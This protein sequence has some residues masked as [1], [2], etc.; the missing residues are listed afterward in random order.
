[1]L[2]QKSSRI[3]FMGDSITDCGATYG[4][5]PERMGNGY[6]RYIK[7]Y[8]NSRYPELHIDVINKGISGHRTC[9]LLKRWEDDAIKLKPDIL[10]I[11]IGTNDVWRQFDRP[12]MDVIDADMFEDNLSKMI[13]STRDA[14]DPIIVLFE[15][16]PVEK[17]FRTY[18][19]SKDLEA[20][21]NA[22]IDEY[23]SRVY[24]TASRYNT[25]LCP[26]N[27]ILKS[28]M[29]LNPDVKY[30]FDGVHP[31]PAGIMTFMLG[32]INTLGL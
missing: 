25:Y 9:D 2:L 26:I 7:D 31:G 22:L 28:N 13:S 6:P 4:N 30:T 20:S 29:S 10:S 24:R 11:C 8:L 21:G 19:C 1:M 17:G 23:N 15:I 5:D 14:I 16:P 27:K 18:T 12:D 3:V 32:F